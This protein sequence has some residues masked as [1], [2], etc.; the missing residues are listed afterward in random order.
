MLNFVRK[1]LSARGLAVAAG[2]VLTPVGLVAL[3]GAQV[4]AQPA[5]HEIVIKV[6]RVKAL[7]EYDE[8][9]KGEFYGRASIGGKKEKSEVVRNE[10]DAKTNW[11]FSF[12][13][14][15][16]QHDVKLELLDKDLSVDDPIDINRLDRK[17]DLDFTV[18]TRTCRIEGFAQVYR[19][20]TLIT[21]TGAEKKKAAI[22][23][24]V[25][26]RRR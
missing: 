2:I 8:F 13:V 18:N 26:V 17:R 1:A 20:G 23:F 6:T 15:P 5:T 25:A 4:Q 10:T 19:C 24:T 3:D 9:S 12:P 22:Y 16:G 11:T 14:T 7:D 21:R